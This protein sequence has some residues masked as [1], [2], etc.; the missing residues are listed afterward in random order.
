MNV[1]LWLEM[2]FGKGVKLNS[3][4]VYEL[5]MVTLLPS[6]YYVVLCSYLNIFV[7]WDIIFSDAKV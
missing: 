1:E 4:M 2:K 3:C 5:D 6:I 7:F